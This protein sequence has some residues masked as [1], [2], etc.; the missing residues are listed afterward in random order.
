MTHLL[1]LG[2]TGSI[3]TQTLDL[4]RSSGGALTVAGLA[5]G[6]SWEALRDQARE[7]RPRFVAL[8]DEAAAVRLAPELPRGTELL[9]G[10]DAAARLARE[11]SYDTCVH[12]M[13]G[14][15]GLLPSVAVLERGKT[16]ALANKESLVAAGELLMRLAAEHGATLVPVD[17]EHSAVFQCLRGEDLGRVRKVWLT[18]SGGPFRTLPAA[19]LEAVTPAMALAH[20]NWEMGP[21]ITVGSATLMNKALEVIEVHHIFG[22]ER[23]RIDV[24][25]H[26]QSIVHS[27]VEFVDG[28]VI[29]Q[30][31][32]P[33]MRGP[34]WYALNHPDRAPAN[35][36]GFDLAR[37]S[38]LTF[39]APDL[40]RFP[41]LALGFRCVEEGADAGCVLNA[42]DEV[43][44][45][46][47][48]AG[49]LDFRDI[50]RVN[51]RVLDQRPGRAGSLAELL[52]A[53][54]RAREL[55]RAEVSAAAAS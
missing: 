6:R 28:S 31:G 45:A 54:A 25:I 33:D 40:E 35:L 15:A 18:A 17:S 13:V 14:A 51:A 52:A 48:L 10:P 42:A 23:E 5:A 21:R 1:L 22:L 26:P 19:A 46:A 27:M 30:L 3:G 11:A 44:V 4:V 53:D 9:A 2:S 39:E 7:F 20:P 8:A 38:T 50:Q 55:A 43:A 41:A 32:P 47:F 37:F 24:V 16:L 49:E 29:A 12:G 36:V 34:I